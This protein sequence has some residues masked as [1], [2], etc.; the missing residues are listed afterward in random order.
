MYRICPQRPNVQILFKHSRTLV[1]Y[2]FRFAKENFQHEINIRI[3]FL[4]NFFDS[5]LLLNERAAIHKLS[6]IATP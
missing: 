1:Q 6:H 3:H 2:S 4:R 5:F